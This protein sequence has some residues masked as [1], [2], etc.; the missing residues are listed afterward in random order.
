[1][2]NPKVLISILNW[3]APE[4]TA[5]TIQSVLL[6][7]YDNYKIVLLDNNSADNSVEI[8]SN[9]FKDIQ[10]I[11]NKKNLGYAGAHKIAA[12][13]AM[14]ENFDLLWILNNDMEVFSNTLNE[15]VESHKKNEKALLG[16]ISLECDNKTI[17][18]GGG[19]EM[20]KNGQTDNKS[21][22][23]IFSGKNIDTVELLERP[24]SGLQ[25]CSILIP[26]NTIKKYG[27]MNTRFFLYG[28]ETEYCYRLRIRYNIQSIIVPKSKVIHHDGQSF[29][30]EKLKLLRAYYATRNNNIVHKQYDKENQ[31]PAMSVWRLPHYC[32]YFFSH[33]LLKK[34]K[35]KDF[36][37]W[38]NY[39]AE[40]ANL[41]SFLRIKGKYLK[42]ENFLNDEF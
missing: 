37:Y 9:S 31:I 23:N 4:I 36:Q 27:F 7:D 39:Y 26:I 3:N 30:N 15:L 29:K 28:E 42:P 33:Y 21:G 8:L 12:K 1:M 17:H 11:M 32:K 6:S 24:V 2:P 10:L 25:G 16:S 20:K 41:H 13:L 18:F 22:Y 5:K 34:N 19:L 35:K 40:L 38:L 14:K